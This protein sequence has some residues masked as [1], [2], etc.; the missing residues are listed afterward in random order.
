V[1]QVIYGCPDPKAG[2]VRS[3]YAL[4]EDPR[5]NHRVEVIGGVLADQ[6]AEILQAFFA[7]LRDAR[8]PSTIE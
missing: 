7:G 1:A 3:R 8:E 5:L 2:A 4:C 6:C